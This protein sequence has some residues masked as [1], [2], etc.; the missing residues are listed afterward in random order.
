MRNLIRAI[1]VL[2]LGFCLALWPTA[3]SQYIVLVLGWCF[4][5]AGVAT[6]IY[7]FAT[8]MFIHI[9]GMGYLTAVSAIIFLAL[10]CWMLFMPQVFLSI[11]A[12]LFGAVLVVYGIAQII[13]T[14]RFTKG[15]KNKALVY[16]LPVIALI[17]GVIFFFRSKD[18]LKL[19][20]MLF[21]FGLILFGV[22]EIILDVKYVKAKRVMKAAA[23]A[24]AA[25]I[26]AG[27]AGPAS[28]ASQESSANSQS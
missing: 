18:A 11:I 19:L 3:S 13:H 21:G 2:V 25:K 14:Y 9:V 22:A 15:S 4:I 12:F 7:A 6:I 10:G 20:T 23:A 8:R 17:I 5:A 1:F 28:T 16:T 24:E 27:Q 26:V